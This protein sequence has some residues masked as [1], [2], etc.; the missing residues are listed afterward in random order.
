MKNLHDNQTIDLFE[1][2]EYISKIDDPASD[3]YPSIEQLEDE[4]ILAQAKELEQSM[5]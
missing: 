2:E 3:M 1:E 5:Y 4:Y